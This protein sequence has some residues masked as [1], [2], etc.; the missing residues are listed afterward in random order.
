MPQLKDGSWCCPEC[1]SL[2][3]VT[4]NHQPSGRQRTDCAVC[5]AYVKWGD[6]ASR[7]WKARAIDYIKTRAHSGDVIAQMLLAEIKLWP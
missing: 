3:L 4:Y 1:G 7:P 5:H 2:E 6:T